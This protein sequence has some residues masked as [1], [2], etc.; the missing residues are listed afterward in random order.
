MGCVYRPSKSQYWRITFYTDGTPRYESAR[1]TK[2]TEAKRLLVSARGTR[3]AASVDRIRYEKIAQGLR[4][5]GATAGARNL[6]RRRE[7][8][9][10]SAT[11]RQ[12]NLR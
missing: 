1:T 7:G 6:T 8:L 2:R 12:V 4:N 5:H 9:M 10:P 11:V 3:A